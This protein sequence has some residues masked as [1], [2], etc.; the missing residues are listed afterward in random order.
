[1]TNTLNTPIE[2]LEMH[3]PLRITRYEIRRGSGGHGE[4]QGGD[5][6]IREFE[7]LR[8]TQVTLLTERRLHQPWGLRNADAGAMGINYLNDELLPGKV[9]LQLQAGDRIR[10]ETAGG[11][12]I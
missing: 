2:A 6:L 4:Y 1:M 9:E 12:G 8:P 11:G 5:G 7:Y 3:Y 10:I